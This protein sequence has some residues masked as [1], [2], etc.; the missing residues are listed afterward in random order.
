MDFDPTPEQAQRVGRAAVRA[1]RIAPVS[2]E[3]IL[4][5]VA[6]HVL[7]QERSY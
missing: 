1:G 4:N 7:G 3:M 6:Q 2:S 5:Y